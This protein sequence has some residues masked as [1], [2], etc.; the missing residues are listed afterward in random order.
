[1]KS[2]IVVGAGIAGL[3]SAYRLSKAGYAVTI[4]EGAREPG[5]MVAHVDLAGVSVDSGAEAFAVRGGHA[6]ALC[7]E[8]GVAV[9]APLGEPRLWWSEGQFPVG[10]GVL[11]IP[12]ALDDPA[13]ASAGEEGRRAV[14]AEPGL[15]PAIGAHAKTVGELVRARLGDHVLIRC[16]EPVLRGIFG[17]HADRIGI[18]AV[19]PGLTAEF[20]ASGSLLAA[21]ATLR[22][23]A[24]AVV[25]QPVGGMHRLVEALVAAVEAG[26]GRIVTG[27]AV[28]GLHR[29]K[30]G[31]SVEGRA[32]QLALTER[33]VLAV[34]ASVAVALLSHLG[35]ELE[36]PPV[37]HTRQVLLA[38]RSDAL[39]A[40][41]VGSGVLVAGAHGE[42][43]AKALSHY[44]ARWPWARSTGL[45]ILRLSYPDYVFPTR[46][47][48]LHD[49]ALLTGVQLPDSAVPALVSVSWDQLPTP[50]EPA[51][52]NLLVSAAAEAGVDI[53]GAWLDGNGVDAVTAGTRRVLAE[54]RE[55]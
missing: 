4:F 27:T 17:V 42:L 28:T 47:E 23:R 31:I 1:M 32:G 26:G 24:G 11:G 7:D 40:E 2:A 14:E 45:E 30:E 38:A 48:V 20:A 16:V 52:R 39:A 35:A 21:A 49:V 54:R 43:R 51:H 8:L 33:L 36:A 53:V 9:A 5:G 46:A 29:S 22:G 37:R 18:E 19:A 41:P 6:R 50:V 3:V 12:I 10:R 44:S 55:A 15:D 13:L 34:P 25:E